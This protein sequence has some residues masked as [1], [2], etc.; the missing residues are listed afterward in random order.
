MIQPGTVLT[1]QGLAA[2]EIVGAAKISAVISVTDLE[3]ATGT[4][5]TIVATVTVGATDARN[6][7]VAVREGAKIVARRGAVTGVSGIAVV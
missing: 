6:L 2:T 1:S 5:V 7:E 3:V 4:G